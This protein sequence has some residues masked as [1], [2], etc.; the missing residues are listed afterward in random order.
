MANGLPFE[1]MVWTALENVGVD[2]ETGDTCYGPK[3][4]GKALTGKAPAWFGDCIHLVDVKSE[5]V[6]DDGRTDLSKTVKTGVPVKKIRAYMANHPHKS[7]HLYSA[8]G[9]TSAWVGKEMPVFFDV[10]INENEQKGLNWIY[11]Q[12]DLLNDK[13]AETIASKLK[14]PPPNFDFKGK[15]QVQVLLPENDG[16]IDEAEAL[17]EEGIVSSEDANGVVKEASN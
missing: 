11:E 7:G 8:K 5:E 12:E 14:R 17:K 4:I 15:K 16:V 6:I 9:R 1:K 13:A 3:V 10:V 2:P